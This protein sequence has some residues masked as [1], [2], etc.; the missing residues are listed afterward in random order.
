[1]LPSGN[2]A[3]LAI[4]VW[5]GKLLTEESHGRKKKLYYQK[6]ISEMNKKA[7]EIG[8]E[9]T[10][11]A[12]SHGLVNFANKSCAFDLALLSE[13][14]MKNEKFRAIVSCKEYKNTISFCKV[15][16]IPQQKKKKTKFWEN[17]EPCEDDDKD[18]N[19]E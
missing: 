1:M 18:L 13:Y 15:N 10:T 3:S 14:A 7:R 11:Y 17:S 8:M 2:D 6:F 16:E 4:A 19:S 9:K 5:G 12:N